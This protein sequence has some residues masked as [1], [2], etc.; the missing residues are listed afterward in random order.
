MMPKNDMFPKRLYCICIK[1]DA[2][3]RIWW[4]MGWEMY[5]KG[6]LELFIIHQVC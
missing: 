4:K 2:F 6:A 5:G 1:M 3:Q